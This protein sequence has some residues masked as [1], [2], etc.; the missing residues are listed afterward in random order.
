VTN[1]IMVRLK[2]DVVSV[3]EWELRMRI[4]VENVYNKKRIGMDVPRLSIWER[5]RRIYFMSAKSTVSSVDS[6]KGGIG[7]VAV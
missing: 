4:I 5:Q 3:A 1:A 6:T 7:A 2:A